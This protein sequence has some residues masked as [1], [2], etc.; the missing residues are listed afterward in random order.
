MAVGMD[1]LH[2]H[3]MALEAVR[4]TG[5]VVLPPLPLGTETYADPERLRHRGFTGDERIYG[6][7]YPGFS[8]PSLY[9]EESAMG[10]V[11]HDLIRA[12]KRQ[13]FRVIVITNGHGATNHRA[14]LQRIATEQS[15]P[16]RV[17][18]LLAGYFYDTNY[19]EHAA[20]GETSFLLAYHPQAID[21]KALPPLPEPLRYIDY[22][23]L[24][25]PTIVGEPSPG[26]EVVPDWDP[27][28][29]TAERGK[30]DVAGEAHSIAAKVRAALASVGVGV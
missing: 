17:A 4:L 20:I 21:L 25:R 12:L 2:G 23:I 5:G 8:L 7:D 13:E 16:G 3:A 9:L 15:E 19:R 10:V 28:N 14:T 29:A 24:D 1:M 6:M 18:V 27:R 30:N 11:I 26:F 22:G